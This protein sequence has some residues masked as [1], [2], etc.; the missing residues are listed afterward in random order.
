MNNVAF[1]KTIKNVRKY[2]NIK[3]LIKLVATERKINYLVSEPNYHTSKIF[4]KNLSAKEMRKTQI[5]MNKTI[6]LGLSILYI[7]KNVMYE[8]WFDYVKPRHCKNP[9]FCYMD[10]G[11]FIVYKKRRYLQRHRR[12]C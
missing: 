6:Y 7:S 9:K 10:T 12:R 1:G 11:S 4:T 3:L 8:F 2:G 5:L